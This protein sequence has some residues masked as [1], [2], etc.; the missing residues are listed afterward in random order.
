MLLQ[1]KLAPED[2]D[3][4][5]YLWRDLQPNEAPK[6]YRMQRLTLTAYGAAM[7]I[8]IRDKQDNVSSQLVIS[9]SRVTPIKK[10]SLPRLEHLAA[11]VK[12]QVA[13]ICCKGFANER[14]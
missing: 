11:L 8:R 9:K 4:H 6:V 3:V 13:K 2:R 1:V 14:G 10:V 5:R 12:C 7:Y